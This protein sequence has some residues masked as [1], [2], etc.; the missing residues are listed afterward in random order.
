MTKQLSKIVILGGGSAGWMTAA[1]LA[2]QLNNQI[3]ITLIESEKIGTIGVGEATIPPIQNFNRLLEIDENEFLSRCNG[4]IKLG[5]EFQNWG[6]IG[7]SYMHPFGKLGVDFDYM[8]FPYFWLQQK[9]R[10]KVA[11]IQEFSL[12]W[13]LAN[14]KKFCPIEAVRPELQ[15][16]YDYAYHFDATSYA[17]FLRE[18]SEN[19]GVTRVEGQVTEVNTCATSGFVTSMVMDNQNIIDADFFIDCSGQKALLLGET[20]KVDFN[21]WS[22]YLLNDSAVAVQSAHMQS[23]DPYT[24]SIAHSCGWQWR[25]PL[26]TRMGNGNVFSSQFMDMEQGTELLLSEIQGPTLSEP[27]KIRFKTGK[28]Q[29]VWSKNVLAIGL[30]AGFLEPLES[31]SLHLVQSAIM[32][33]IR[34]FP[35][36]TMSAT[37]LDEYNRATDEEYEMIRDFI[38]LHYKATQRDDSEYWRYCSE[39]EI[40][41]SLQEKLAMYLEYGHIKVRDEELFK[42]DNWLA[43]LIGQHQLPSQS[44]PILT[45][46]TQFDFQQISTQIT[47][48]M[49]Q[50]VAQSLSHE[51]YLIKHCRYKAK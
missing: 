37:L 36:K 11:D 31:T 45:G 5:I 44:A 38:I 25:I 23:V 43:V 3:Q 21:N 18:Y 9:L 6:K 29:K 8:P 4:S 14:K 12:A 47:K 33:L 22:E 13:Q 20:L 42:Q 34:L 1:M 49:E 16:G 35:D 50:Q 27:N 10:G 51:M 19:R 7:D 30:S 15:N 28:R 32:R 17:A 41:T 39:M 26:Q 2:K 40:P 48:V 46:K 24:K